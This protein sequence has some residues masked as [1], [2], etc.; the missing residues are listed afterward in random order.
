MPSTGFRPVTFK[1]K[2]PHNKNCEVLVSASGFEPETVPTK[3]G[4]LYPAELCI[5]L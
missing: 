1:N 5:N 2:K 3:I 4:M